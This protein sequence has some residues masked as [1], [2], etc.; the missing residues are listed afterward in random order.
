MKIWY[1]KGC[2]SGQCLGIELFTPSGLNRIQSANLSYMC[3]KI[4]LLMQ[5][6]TKVSI[7]D[8]RHSDLG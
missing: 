5:N 6:T 4:Y 3:L 7:N 8:Q 2:F 1:L